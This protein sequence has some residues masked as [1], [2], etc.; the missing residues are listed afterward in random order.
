M[1]AGTKFSYPRIECKYCG[2][3]IA[4]NWM[5]RHTCEDE[6]RVREMLKKSKEEREHENSLKA[7]P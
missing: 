6:K 5:V 2:K 3:M 7:I 4:E 1:K